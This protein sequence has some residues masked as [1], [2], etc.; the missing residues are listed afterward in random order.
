MKAMVNRFIAGTAALALAG[1]LVMASASSVEAR[2]RNTGAFLGG[3]AAGAIIGGVVASQP[4]YYAPGYYA[5]PPP[6]VYAAPEYDDAVAYC[7][8]RFKS[9]DPASGTY[10]GYDGYRKPCP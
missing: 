3:L 9:Y 4:R 1:S 10:L 5:P 6:A 8:S 7:M 2:S